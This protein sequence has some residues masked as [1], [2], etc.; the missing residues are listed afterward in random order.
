MAANTN[1]GINKSK[2]IKQF[3]DEAYENIA[4]VESLL[5]KTREGGSVQEDITGLMRALHTLKGSSRMLDFLNIEILSHALETVFISLRDER[6]SINDRAIRLLLAGLDELKSGIDKVKVDGNDDFDADFLTNELAA[7]AA[8]EEFI[9]PSEKE[10]KKTI[11]ALDAGDDKSDKLKSDSIRISLDRINEVIHTMA[12][13]QS[14]E[15]TARNIA[16]DTGLIDASSW[17]FSRNITADQAWNSPLLQE[18]RAM[19]LQISKLGSLVRNFSLD[20]GNLIRS[21]YDSVISLRMLPLSTVLDAYPRQVFSIA[22]ELGKQV[23]ITIEGAENEIDK[24]LIE[25]L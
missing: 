15:I 16:R 18:F 22:S 2:Y 12:T 4:V 7:L 23:K 5:I 9:L 8:N 24:N 11:A 17:Q 20:A 13:L 3:T 14:L 1:P 21:A 25:S 19:E 10:K 6:I